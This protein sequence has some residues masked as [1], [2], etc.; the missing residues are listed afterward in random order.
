MLR[1]SRST[2]EVEPHLNDL[3]VQYWLRSEVL[4]LHRSFGC[5]PAE[6]EEE[7]RKQCGPRRSQR[8][9][10]F[11]AHSALRSRCASPPRACHQPSVRVASR[12]AS[13]NTVSRTTTRLPSAS[14]GGPARATRRRQVTSIARRE[15][16]EAPKQ[17][18]PA[19]RRVASAAIH[20]ARRP[21]VT[22]HLL[23][24]RY[25]HALLRIST[26]APLCS[27]VLPP[28]QP[29]FPPSF[30]PALHPACRPRGGERWAEALSRALDKP[31]RPP[32][33]EDAVVGCGGCPA[34]GALR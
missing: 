29:P 8:I 24:A 34:Q 9:P 11:G 33:H 16:E 20:E 22:G 18:D 3:A 1:S 30:A 6:A 12:S 31:P 4:H 5:D 23:H 17:V 26:A 21:V 27:P 10:R 15:A 2:V 19:G 28:L 32:H 13:S 14:D 25:V 7:G